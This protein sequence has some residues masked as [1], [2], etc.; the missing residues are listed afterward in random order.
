MVK[1]AIILGVLFGMLGCANVQRQDVETVGELHASASHVTQAPVH[2]DT[3]LS[4]SFV[5]SDDMEVK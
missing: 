4:F 3:N 2:A 1:K 5:S